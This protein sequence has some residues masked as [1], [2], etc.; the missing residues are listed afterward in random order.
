[1]KDDEDFGIT[2][3]CTGPEDGEELERF[4]VTAPEDFTGNFFEFTNKHNETF[5][6]LTSGYV[7]EVNPELFE[8]TDDPFKFKYKKPGGLK[9]IFQ[10][11]NSN[12]ELMK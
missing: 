4:K 3:E 12:V 8:Q 5:V 10:P 6:Q 9:K 11:Q 1:M 7:L 2:V